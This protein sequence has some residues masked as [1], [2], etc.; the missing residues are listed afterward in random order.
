MIGFD[1]GPVL[2]PGIAAVLLALASYLR[3]LST[4]PKINPARA[5][6]KQLSNDVADIAT[7]ADSTHDL[8]NSRM[9]AVIDD[10]RALSEWIT[11]NAR[12]GDPPPPKMK[13]AEQPPVVPPPA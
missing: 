6:R 5:E 3:S 12:P 9:T 7:T 11:A 4:N 8:V 13:S 2:A 10:V 1:W